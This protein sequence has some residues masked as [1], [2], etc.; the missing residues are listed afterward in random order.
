MLPWR[1]IVVLVQIILKFTFWMHG[2][3]VDFSI[4]CY[5]QKPAPVLPGASFFVGFYEQF[6]VWSIFEIDKSDY[7]ILSSQTIFGM[8]IH[9]CLSADLSKK[10]V[11]MLLTFV[12]FSFGICL[13][14]S[15]RFTNRVSWRTWILL[16][17]YSNWCTPMW[18]RIFFVNGSVA[19]GVLTLIAVCD[20]NGIDF[21]NFH[22]QVRK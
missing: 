13:H 18:Q 12:C 20:F 6:C 19:S 3:L 7:T 2:N 22:G 9:C 4:P 21:S 15:S 1:Y 8:E 11:F 14:T 5:C 17:C 10:I 16:L